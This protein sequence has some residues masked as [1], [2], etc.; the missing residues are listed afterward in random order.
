MIKTIL[1]ASAIASVAIL[2]ACSGNKGWTV[3]GKIQDPVQGVKVAVDGFGPLGT[4]YNI[5]SVEV[6]KNGDFKY[7]AFQGSPYP[8][9]YRLTYG[10]KSVYFPIDS[11]EFVKV[12][13]SAANF[14]KDYELSGS[15]LA[16]QLMAVDKL[17][18]AAAAKDPNASSDAALKRQLAEIALSDTI[19]ITS[20]YLIN[21]TIAGK[22]IFSDGDKNDVRLIGAVANKFAQRL[23][24]DPRTAF[25]TQRFLAARKSLGMGA[26]NTTVVEVPEM[27]LIDID[28]YDVK[29]KKQTLSDLA[30][31]KKIT[32]LS[33]TAYSLDAS[34]PYNIELNKVFEK[35]PGLG[36]YQVAFDADEAQWAK[37]AANMPWTAVRYDPT[38][39]DTLLRLYNVGA[40]P[41]TFII[42]GDG[43]LVERVTD[44]TQIDAAIRKHI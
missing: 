23:P 20:Y 40:L 30:K 5:D 25:L 27:G 12:T 15:D 38:K 39:G 42:N 36:I 26:Q 13:A 41:A 14:D 3:S 2:A 22:P 6:S 18:S 24:N 44:P 33:F 28:L 4:W 7:R 35:Y 8:D 34:T 31:S 43:D 19:G 17:I 21:K 29:G 11:L 9:V 32:V 16:A 1:K 10:G 37:S